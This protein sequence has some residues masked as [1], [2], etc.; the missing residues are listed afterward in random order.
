M[1]Y[2][3]VYIVMDSGREISDLKKFL[4]SPF[5]SLFWD[6]NKNFIR[7]VGITKVAFSLDKTDLS[8]CW[9]SRSLTNENK[10]P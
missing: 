8:D 3:F 2:L 7:T 9:Y 4:Y 5:G 1:Y 10:M 6:D